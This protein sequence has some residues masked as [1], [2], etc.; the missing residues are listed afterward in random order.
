M[1]GLYNSLSN[2]AKKVKSHVEKY[3]NQWSHK[4]DHENTVWDQAQ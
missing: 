3:W 2:A 1:I 4:W